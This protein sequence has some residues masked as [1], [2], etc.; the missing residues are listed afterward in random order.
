M[1]V[2]SNRLIRYAGEA[3]DTSLSIITNAQVAAIADGL[4]FPLDTPRTL[5]FGTGGPPGEDVADDYA[6]WYERTESYWHSWVGSLDLPGD[7][8][9]AVARAAITLALNVFEET[10]AIIASITTSI[11]EAPDSGRNWDYRY[12]WPRAAFFVADSLAKLGDVRTTERLLAFVLRI[13]DATPGSQLWPLYTIDGGLI[14]EERSAPEE[15]LDG[16]RGLGPVRI[17]NGA[18]AQIH[19]AV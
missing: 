13:A 5:L 15:C 6:R 18:R 12:C 14:P 7:R 3:G 9:D 2:V 10:G 17:G 4:P 16:Y 11:P 19:H 1:P 8:R